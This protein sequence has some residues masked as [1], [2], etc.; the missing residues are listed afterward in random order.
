MLPPPNPKAV[1]PAL[2]ITNVIPSDVFEPASCQLNWNRVWNEVTVWSEVSGTGVVRN[3]LPR[4]LL[5]AGT[6]RTTDPTWAALPLRVRPET[7]AKL[8]NV[9]VVGAAW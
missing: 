6:R 2:W 5:T 8:G 1:A 7:L 3:T 9:I 4:W